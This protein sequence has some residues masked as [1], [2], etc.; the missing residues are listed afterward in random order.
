MR[1]VQQLIEEITREA[2]LTGNLTGHSH[3][4]DAVLRAM[5][6]I[7]REA[8]IAD[9]NLSDAY[10]NVPLPIGYGQTISQPF[11]VALMTDLLTPNSNKICLEIGTGS[12]YQ[13]AILA[14]LV[15]QVYTL[16][17]IES[18][19]HSAAA[20]LEKLGFTNIQCLLGDGNHG[21]PAYAPYDAIIVTA[22][23]NIIPAALIEQLKPGGRMVIPV[24]TVGS[25]QTLFLVEKDRHGKIYCRP[26]LGVAFVPL[27]TR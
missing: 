18:L 22:C 13:A 9:N 27:V 16:E 15:K 2:Q 1:D 7:P 17:V 21:Y 12:G 11:I 8:F 4:S 20:R 6:D 19:H 10:L 5:Q 23:A 24:G 3:L 25:S 26:K 14:T